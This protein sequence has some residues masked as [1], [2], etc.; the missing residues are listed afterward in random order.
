MDLAACAAVYRDKLLD[1]VL[2][3]WLRHSLD[4]R[5]G[6]Y[7]TCLDRR[8][9]VFD[10][11]KFMWLQGRQVWTLAKMYRHI[12]ARA[13]W[14]D[15]ARLGAEFIRDHGFDNAGRA[16]F[17]LGRAG[18]PYA[19]PCIFS[20]C[21]CA[22]GLAEY[23]AADGA[24]WARELAFRTYSSVQRWLETKDN[25][26]PKSV[27]GARPME[28]MVYDMINV[29]MSLELASTIDDPAFRR[30]GLASMDRIGRLFIDR[31]E[32]RVFE[33]VAP[34]GSHPDTFKGRLVMPGHALECL[35]FLIQAGREWERDDAA[36]AAVAAMPDMLQFGWDAE[37]G[38]FHYFMDARGK[39][40]EQLE[41]DQKL[42]WVH[43]EALVAL[44]EAYRATG[45][46]EFA[47]WFQKV[48]DYTWSH[49]DD[50]ECGEW[51]G[52]LHRRGDPVMTLKGGKWKGCF[53]VPRTLWRC[54][55]ILEDLKGRSDETQS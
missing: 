11:D 39:P 40:P 9:E 54:W 13:E 49:F 51:Y 45:R 2:P 47:A 1:D 17:A 4:R 5:C 29:N 28:S 15:A 12:E 44:L 41:W 3:F 30:A 33:H 36:D 37:H 7:F 27:A 55:Q 50:A 23:A 42:W 8:G 52:Y 6:G 20:D 22:M 53:H 24:D 48:H 16:Y 35:W 14:L 38:G 31:R 46:E 25:P 21:F 43:G 34:D 18:Q 32:G 10:T 19:R 26:Y